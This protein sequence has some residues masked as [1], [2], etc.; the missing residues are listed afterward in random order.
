MHARNDLL[1]ILF[2]SDL[3]GTTVPAALKPVQDA[4]DIGPVPV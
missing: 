4:G 3:I 2:D 1:Q